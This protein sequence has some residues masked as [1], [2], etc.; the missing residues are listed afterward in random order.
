MLRQSPVR[1]WVGTRKGAFAFS[2]KDRK[3]WDFDGPFFAGQEV[4]HVVQDPR[5]P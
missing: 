4:H 5:D 1:I 3:K 2:S